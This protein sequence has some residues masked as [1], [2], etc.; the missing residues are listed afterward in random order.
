MTVSRWG[1][2]ENMNKAIFIDK[3]GTLIEDIPYNVDP[4]RIRFAD[5]ATD[6][7]R[8]LK[9]RGYLLIMVSNQSGIAHGYFAEDALQKL[10]DELQ[11]ILTVSG[12][13]FDA[14][15][16]CPHHPDGKVKAYSRICECRKP[17]PGMLLNAAQRFDIDPAASW[18]IGD[19][20]NDVEA[21]NQ[22]GCKT[23]LIDNGNETEWVLS[24]KR[25]PT[26]TALNL[27]EAAELI[28][29]QFEF[30]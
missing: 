19:I 12:I 7:L 28:I 20:L 27:K 9:D 24:G 17:K 18:M 1:K 23:I 25:K 14:F 4:A 13:P 2:R 16:F 15:F 8:K 6:G 22:A 5:G 29:N 21:G 11:R 30:A 10:K 26:F 3:D